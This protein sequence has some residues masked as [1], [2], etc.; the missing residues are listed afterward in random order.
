MAELARPGV[1]CV[2][3]FREL[4]LFRHTS[5]YGKIMGRFLLQGAV[6][7]GDGDFLDTSNA[8]ILASS[9]RIVFSVQTRASEKAARRSKDTRPFDA[10]SV[11]LHR[12]NYRRYKHLPWPSP[13]IAPLPSPF[14]CIPDY[15]GRPKRA[16]ESRTVRTHGVH[17]HT[18]LSPRRWPQR[19]RLLRR[20][21]IT[22]TTKA[23]IILQTSGYKMR[24]RTDAKS[25]L[26]EGEPQ[27]NKGEIIYPRAF[28]MYK[29][30][31]D[32]ED[33]VALR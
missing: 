6:S 31:S 8:L 24:E 27:F 25:F 32:T 29:F 21:T 14:R 15:E 4:T 3:L 10:H 33:E 1:I 7:G 23:V 22:K 18:Q 2:W 5:M 13:V 28:L 16:E 12:I 17:G 9:P 30:I 26:V 19:R 20:A 11:E